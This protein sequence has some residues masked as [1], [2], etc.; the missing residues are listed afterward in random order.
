[1]SRERELKLCAPP[2]FRLPDL[3]DLAAGLAASAEG[4]LRQT[5]VYFDT[6]ELRL[7]RWD[8]VL[9]WRQ[10]DGWSA[11][12]P[13]V[14]AEEGAA[15]LRRQL[16]FEGGPEAPPAAAL[17]VLRGLTRGAQLREIVRLRTIRRR[18][19]IADAEG[20]EL[21]EL[22]SDHFGRL[23]AGRVAQRFREVEVEVAP[24]CPE[25]LVQGVVARLRQAGAGPASQAGKHLRALG[26]E[27]SLAPEVEV[28]E[29][30]LDAAAALTLRRAVA[31][32][33]VALMRHDAGVRAGADTEAV[34]QMRVATRRLRSHLRSFA[35]LVDEAWA[36]ALRD[37]LRWLGAELGGVRDADVLGARL[38]AAA[39]RLPEQDA[40]AAKDLLGRLDEAR[41]AALASLGAALRSPRYLELAEALVAA[42]RAP[43]TTPAADAPARDLLPALVWGCWRRLSRRVKQLSDAPEA[44]DLH[45]TRIRAKHARYAAEALEPLYGRRARRLARALRDVQQILGVHQDASVALAWLTDAAAQAP[46]EAAFAAGM[47]AAGEQRRRDAAIADWRRAW[48]AAA[49]PRRRDWLRKALSITAV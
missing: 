35:P 18:L 25:E 45:A 38:R 3:T 20:R 16:H 17:E 40:R 33:V 44:A 37:E 28:P 5:S 23:E 48:E 7:A 14:G 41:E 6:P 22:T 49:A 2:R 24:G 42:G 29:V 12:L 13:P 4:P 30:S 39:E 31:L 21:L 19:G 43:R 1:M 34:H 36:T 32:S 10:G 26:L 47:L 9:R 8:C 11:K 46:R 15:C 27:G